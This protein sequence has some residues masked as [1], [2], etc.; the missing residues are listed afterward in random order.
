MAAD[1]T[2]RAVE[3]TLDLLEF[4][5]DNGPAHLSTVTEELGLAKSTAHRHLGT[6]EHRGYV[7]SSDSGYTLSLRFLDFGEYTRMRSPEYELAAEK[8][9]AIA[10]Q[11]DERAQF[12]VEEHGQ[13]VYVYHQAGQHAVEAN[14]YPGKRVPIHASAAGLAI[15]S[16]YEKE[17]VDAIINQHGL[18]SLTAQTITDPDTLY[19]ELATTRKRG[20]SINDQGVIEGLRAIGVSVCGPDG[21]VIGGL[22]VS[23]PINRMDGERFDETLPKLLLGATNELELNIAYR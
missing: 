4:L 16:E 20:Y 6:L 9:L 19:E 10:K 11:T 1:D 5:R 3:R 18:P 8:V 22:S 21:E 15:L 23:G 12:M 17:R 13:A 2:V 14:T 7:T